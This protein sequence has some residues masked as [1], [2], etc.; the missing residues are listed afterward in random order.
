MVHRLNGHEPEQT[1]GDCEGHGS[2]A[3]CSPWDRKESW[4][5]WLNNN[6][7]SKGSRS[8]KTKKDCGCGCG[9]GHVRA[10]N[11]SAVCNSLQPHGLQPTRFLCLWDFPVKNT[12]LG[13][14]VFFQGSSWPRN[15]TW[16]F[17]IS[18]I[19]RGSFTNA[20]PPGKPKKDWE[21]VYSRF[22]ATKERWLVKCHVWS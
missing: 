16:V 9:C 19:A 11:C 14:H 22:K 4:L 12:G 21:T 10:L 2:L 7:S 15:Q 17:R 1:P 20:E 13:C 18:C 5:L 3:F 6:N 8:R